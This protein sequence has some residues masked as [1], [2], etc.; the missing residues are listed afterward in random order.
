[1]IF[2]SLFRGAA[3]T[4]S[5]PE[6]LLPVLHSFVDIT[7]MGRA[8][9]SVSVES[10]G[11]EE[12]VVGD[13]LGRSGEKGV[14][15]YQTPAGKFRFGSIIAGVKDGMTHFRMPE[16]VESLGGGAQ[17]RSSVRMDVLVS[18]SW[19]LAPGGQGTGEYVKGSIRD[20]SRGG[21]ALIADRPCKAGQLLEIRM[22]LRSDAAP[23]TVLGEVMRFEQIP[24]SGKYSHGLRFQGLTA[25][26]GRAILEFITKKQA[27]LRSRGLA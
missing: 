10:A 18:G 17:K 12:I 26:E 20:I 21:C 2:K 13:A 1:V 5:I 22:N 9:R 6:E 24:T 23:L 15:V 25:E 8:A 7:V 4:K 11:P 19:R 16:R 3:K 14:F 27:E